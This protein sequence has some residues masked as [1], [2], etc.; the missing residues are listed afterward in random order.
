M[1]RWPSLAALLTPVLLA[2]AVFVTPSG[3][4]AT[5]DADTDA[6][7]V[8][9]GATERLPV[10]A[11]LAEQGS[12]VLVIS[13]AEGKVNAPARK[14]CSSPGDLTVYCFDAAPSTTRGEARAIGRLAR[15]HGWATLTV[16]TSTYH[17]PR[18]RLLVERCTAAAVKVQGAWPSLSIVRW[19]RQIAHE[20]G[21]LT[22]AAFDSS[23]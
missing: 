17:L 2:V 19:G 21:G 13:A 20:L 18:A 7:V 10:A 8:L 14:L 12:G 22:Q 6:V 11:Q 4:N 3:F 1:T 23:C 16:V 9:A 5:G 15:Q